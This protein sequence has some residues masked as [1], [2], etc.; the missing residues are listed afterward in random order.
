MD[1]RIDLKPSIGR[2]TRF[3]NCGRYMARQPFVDRLHIVVAGVSTGVWAALASQNPPG[4]QPVV[5]ALMA[6]PTPFVP[7]IV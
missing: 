2:Q 3:A 5:R 6:T 7:R 4:V 1:G